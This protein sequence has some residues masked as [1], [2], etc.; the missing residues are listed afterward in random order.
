[1]RLRALVL[2]LAT[3]VPAV[4]ASGCGAGAGGKIMAETKVP[5]PENPDAVLLPYLAPD[6]SELTGIEED[7]ADADASDDTA[8]PAAEP[9][10]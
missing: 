4:L 10:K 1:M 7:D 5:T 9:Q 8:A 3:V 2:F 6:I